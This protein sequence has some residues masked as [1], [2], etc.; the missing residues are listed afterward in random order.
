MNLAPAV[1]AVLLA[2]IFLT[3]HTAKVAAQPM[4]A[5]AA[6]PSFLA[7]EDLAALMTGAH[8]GQ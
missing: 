2:L 8:R 1:L 6:E 4:R 5:R 7:P 3:L